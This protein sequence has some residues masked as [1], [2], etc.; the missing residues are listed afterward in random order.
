MV[1]NLEKGNLWIDRKF[2][3]P[4]SFYQFWLRCDDRDLPKFIRF[5]TFKSKEEV[6]AL[7]AEFMETNPN[8][9]KQ[10]LAEELTERIFSKEELKSVQD[11]TA[12]LFNKKASQEQLMSLD[13]ESLEMIVGE[14]KSFPVMISTINDHVNILDLLSEHTAISASKSEARRSIKNNAIS[15]NKEKINSPDYEI[16][17]DMLLHNKF[18]MIENGKKNKYMIVAQ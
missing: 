4:Y 10:L 11:V 16:K 9:L 8:H 12:L 5:F 18:I 6:E 2:T 14:V 3:S 15:V 7:E 17:S 1:L 13:K